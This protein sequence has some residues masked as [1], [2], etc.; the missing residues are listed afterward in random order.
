[1]HD[2]SSVSATP[3]ATAPESLMV[4]SH[5]PRATPGVAARHQGAT[6]PSG[7][8]VPAEEIDACNEEPIKQVISDSSS[9][10]DQLVPVIR[11][12]PMLSH[13][14]DSSRKIRYR[15]VAKLSPWASPPGSN[16]RTAEVVTERRYSDFIELEKRLRDAFAGRRGFILPALA[17]KDSRLALANESSIRRR[18]QFLTSWLRTVMMHR[19]IQ[20][21]PNIFQDFMCNG[22]YPAAWIGDAL[23]A[24]AKEASNDA[25]LHRDSLLSHAA[26]LQK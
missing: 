3:I 23:T 10:N 11:V 6:H 17:P 13:F 25:Q 24:A 9:G 1:M 15:L 19:E 4:Q 14:F 18:V 5:A 20:Q 22:R 16:I 2:L 21:L 12:E 8:D 7:A 26:N